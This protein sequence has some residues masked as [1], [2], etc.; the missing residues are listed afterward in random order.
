M[1]DSSYLLNAS[2]SA[3]QHEGHAFS[4]ITGR[5]FRTDSLRKRPRDIILTKTPN[6][7]SSYLDEVCPRK[8]LSRFRWKALMIGE[9]ASST[10]KILG[11]NITLD[12]LRVSGSRR[13]SNQRR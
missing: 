3:I 11:R 1:V 4:A 13:L 12:I 7:A 6:R 5:E 10:R 8:E 2:V 9:R